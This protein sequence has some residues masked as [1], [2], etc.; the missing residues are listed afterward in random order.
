MPAPNRK[1]RTSRSANSGATA[2]NPPPTATSASPAAITRDGP[3]RSTSAPPGTAINPIISVG[4]ATRKLA[5]ANDRPRSTVNAGSAGPSPMNPL[6]RLKATSQESASTVPG[7]G[8]TDRP[9]DHCRVPIRRASQHRCSATTRG[10]RLAPRRKA[11]EPRRAAVSPSICSSAIR[12]AARSDGEGSGRISTIAG[13]M[14]CSRA[15][16]PAVRVPGT[17]ATQASPLRAVSSWP[18]GCPSCRLAVLPSRHSGILPCLRGGVD[19]RLERARASAR[20]SQGRVWLGTM[21][22]ST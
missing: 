5:C 2:R 16:S 14:T 21:T 19:T 17:R 20:I 1:V 8:L 4:T 3:Q 15:D 11:V 9:A 22:S 6:R 7:P 12:I 18:S 10:A 13:S